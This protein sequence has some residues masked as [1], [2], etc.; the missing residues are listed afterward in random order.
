MG[1]KREIVFGGNTKLFF[2]LIG[3]ITLAVGVLVVAQPSE[4]QEETP[5]ADLR[6]QKGTSRFLEVGKVESF[7][8]SGTR[9]T[10]PIAVGQELTYVIG[11][12]NEGPGTA[13]NLVLED[14]L[15][16]N[17]QFVDGTFEC[18]NLGS[19]VGNT[20]TC[21][22]GDVPAEHGRQAGITVC[23]TAP[24]TVTNTATVRSGTPDPTPTNN[25]DAETTTVV[26]EPPAPGAR[27]CQEA[28]PPPAEETPETKDDCKNEGYKEFGFKNQGQCIKYVNETNK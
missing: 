22:F 8:Q 7:D 1:R 28:P 23:P 6:L 21:N 12:F 14:T 19:V 4:A 27:T 26:S 15:P 2:S 25:T 11:F 9:R 18:S 5:Q 16:P 17:L 20:V 13:T 10:D 3:A 24:G